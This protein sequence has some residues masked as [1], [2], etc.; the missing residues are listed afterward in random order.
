MPSAATTWL[1]GLLDAVGSGAEGT[2]LRQ[3][4][5]HRDPRPSLSV[6]SGATGQ[7]L[8]HCFAGCRTADVLHA[9]RLTFAH[10]SEP[11]PWSPA[12]HVDSWGLRL[13]FPPLEPA[14]G[15][16]SGRRGGL[17]LEASHDYGRWVLERW[18]HP[19]T[20][21]KELTWFTRRNGHLVP[22]LLGVPVRDLPLYLQPQVLM[23]VAAGDTVLVVESESSVDALVRHGLYATTWAGGAAAPDLARL[24]QVL[25]GADVLLVPDHDAPGLACARRIWTALLPVTARLDAVLP[26][27][28]RDAKD[29]IED[30][31]RSAFAA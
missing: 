18:R 12:E 30:A 4:P 13:R 8:L 15:E 26:P 5:A 25:A 22:G 7:V 20:G 16:R 19:V 1:L 24:R 14:S 3:C 23:A 31:G 28:G 29:L 9:L 11:P 21:A 17:R 6:G 2:A 27:P 10:L